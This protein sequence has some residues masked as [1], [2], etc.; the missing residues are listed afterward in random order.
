MCL[1]AN[2]EHSHFANFEQ[3][4]IDSYYYANFEQ[5]GINGY[6]TSFKKV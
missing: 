2:L 1:L 4:K 5:V 6:F 3:V